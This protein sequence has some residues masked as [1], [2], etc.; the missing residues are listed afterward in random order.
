[1][2]KPN[3]GVWSTQ[4]IALELGVGAGT[5]LHTARAHNIGEV[6]TSQRLYQTIDVHHIVWLIMNPTFRGPYP[7][8]DGEPRITRRRKLYSTDYVAGLFGLSASSLSCLRKRYPALG[9]R[10]GKEV[11]FTR[12]DI[13]LLQSR[14]NN[15]HKLCDLDMI[16]TDGQRPKIKLDKNALRFY[17]EVSRGKGEEMRTDR[18]KPGS[19]TRNIVSVY[20]TDELVRWLEDYRRDVGYLSKSQAINHALTQFTRAREGRNEN[21]S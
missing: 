11:I 13:K 1:M 3:I 18:G 15:P 7:W 16:V 6:L 5:L 4:E 2:V 14:A 20:L 8:A 12:L 10:I 21:K 17:D 9:L 19:R